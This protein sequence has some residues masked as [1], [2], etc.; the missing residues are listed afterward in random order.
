MILKVLVPG[1]PKQQLSLQ[2]TG[3]CWFEN[4]NSNPPKP[5][6]YIMPPVG[7]DLAGILVK[8]W[9][10]QK[11]EWYGTVGFNDPLDML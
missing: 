10:P 11:P 7:D 4:A 2:D 1:C 6:A 8:F 3:D 5:S 9:Y